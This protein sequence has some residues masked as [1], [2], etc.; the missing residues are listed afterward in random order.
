MRTIDPKQVE[1]IL[2]HARKYIAMFGM[3]MESAGDDSNAGLAAAQANA[4]AL[5]L[6]GWCHCALDGAE[7]VYWRRPDGSHGWMCARCR[8]ITQAG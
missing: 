3:V 6:D 2:A 4:E 1:T 8:R 7:E 5:R